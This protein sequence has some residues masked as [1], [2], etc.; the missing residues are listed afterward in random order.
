MFTSLISYSVVIEE[1]LALSCPIHET[2][3]RKV[4]DGSMASSCAAIKPEAGLV[5]GRIAKGWV[6]DESLRLLMEELLT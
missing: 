2:E 3:V 4:E 5:W 1:V 6:G